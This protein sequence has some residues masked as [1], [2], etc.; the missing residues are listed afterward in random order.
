MSD[1]V[2]QYAAMNDR[3]FLAELFDILAFGERNGATQDEPE[4]AR[5]MVVSNTL[6]KHLAARLQ[7]VLRRWHE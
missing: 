3:E 2:D 6:L 5:Y 7:V 1:I 4:G